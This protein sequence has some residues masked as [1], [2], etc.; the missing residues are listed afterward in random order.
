MLV[1]GLSQLLRIGADS[2]L[3]RIIEQDVRQIQRARVKGIQLGDQFQIGAPLL[4]GDG[5]CECKVAKIAGRFH[6]VGLRLLQQR[7]IVEDEGEL[8]H[9]VRLEMIEDFAV[10]SGVPGFLQPRPVGRPIDARETGLVDV[11]GEAGAASGPAWPVKDQA[12][13]QLGQARPQA[14]IDRK[15]FGRI[16]E[17][18]DDVFAHPLVRFTDVAAPMQA[19][20]HLLRAERDQ[21]AQ[22]DDPDLGRERPPAVQWVANL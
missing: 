17:I 5:T 15:P 4:R 13:A 12:V 3:P 18:G 21:H 10:Q 14:R 20:D 22:H 2:G 1:E 7:D 19:L 8:P 9:P 11:V 6:L 16:V